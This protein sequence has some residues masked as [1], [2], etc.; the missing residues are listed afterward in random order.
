MRDDANLGEKRKGAEPDGRAGRR[1]S[2]PSNLG[3][4]KRDQGGHEQNRQRR[5]GRHPV[6]SATTLS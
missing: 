1:P 5:Y 4:V 6:R 2:A 3:A